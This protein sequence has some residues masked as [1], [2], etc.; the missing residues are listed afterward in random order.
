[1]TE[2]DQSFEMWAGNDID[3]NFSIVDS[4]GS[5][6]DLTTATTLEWVLHA[7]VQD[8]NPL[9]QKSIG[10]GI[11]IT[12]PGGGQFTITLLPADTATLSGNYYHECEL[13]MG[14]K[15]NTL[16]TGAAKINPTA[17]S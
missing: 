3:L 4:T 7:D 9:I 1:M 16:F 8:G 14:G 12:N 17:I 2:V 15:D 13:N 6:V 10:S 11:T 5:P